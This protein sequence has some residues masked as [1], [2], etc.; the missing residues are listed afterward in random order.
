MKRF[1]CL[2]LCI[3]IAV[4]PACAGKRELTPEQKAGMVPMPFVLK[5]GDNEQ[6]IKSYDQLENALKGNPM[7]F[8]TFFPEGKERTAAFSEHLKTLFYMMGTYT[9]VKSGVINVPAGQPQPI[10]AQVSGKKS[11]AK[12]VQQV[13]QVV[14]TAG[15]HMQVFSILPSVQQLRQY[16]V[17]QEMQAK[18]NDQWSWK[19]FGMNMLNTTLSLGM[20]TLL[21]S[22]WR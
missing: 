19:G 5:I 15:L 2:I 7:Q 1:I 22:A 16:Q 13:Q 17:Q 8:V 12:Q 20:T 18:Y 9:E 4:L 11:K 3:C 10:Q 21:Y 6:L 14:P